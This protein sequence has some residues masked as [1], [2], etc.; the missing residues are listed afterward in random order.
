MLSSG[1]EQSA[2]METSNASSEEKPNKDKTVVDHEEVPPAEPNSTEM[3]ANQTEAVP[4]TYIDHVINDLYETDAK[5]G[6]QTVP[7]AADMPACSEMCSSNLESNES[8]TSLPPQPNPLDFSLLDSGNKGCLLPTGKTFLNS[9]SRNYNQLSD[10]NTDLSVKGCEE[11]PSMY[12]MLDDTE[13]ESDSA[14][15]SAVKTENPQGDCKDTQDTDSDEEVELCYSVVRQRQPNQEKGGS[16]SLQQDISGNQT[17]KEMF[18]DEVPQKAPSRLR[19]VKTTDVSASIT[20][21]Q[22]P[23]PHQSASLES[24]EKKQTMSV[25]QGDLSNPEPSDCKSNEKMEKAVAPVTTSVTHSTVSS[26]NNRHV[27]PRSRDRTSKMHSNELFTSDKPNTVQVPLMSAVTEPPASH[28]SSGK[29]SSTQATKDAETETTHDAKSLFSETPT[30]SSTRSPSEYKT[31]NN[32]PVS[33]SSNSRIR[34]EEKSSCSAKL[35][36]LSIRSKNKG[37]EQTCSKTAKAESPLL[38][39]ANSTPNQSPKLPAKRSAPTSSPQMSRSQDKGISVLIKTGTQSQESNATDLSEGLKANVES[40]CRS[41]TEPESSLPKQTDAGSKCE[42][43]TTQRTFIEVR[44]SSSSS[45]SSPTSAPVLPCTETA[46]TKSIQVQESHLIL[47]ENE[48]SAPKPSLETSTASDSSMSTP[49]R[50]H[51]IKSPNKPND[52]VCSIIS[53]STKLLSS[54]SK[55]YLKALDR[56]SY[57]TDSE[58]LKRHS[59]S[60]QQRIKSFENLASLDR[61]VIK[62]IDIQSYAVGSKAAINKRLSGPLQSNDHRSLKRSLSSCVEMLNFGH[63]FS[64]QS[65]NSSSNAVINNSESSPSSGD[66]RP[67][68][69]ERATPEDAV[70]RSSPVPH[71]PPVLRT[72]NARYNGGILRSK[73]RELRALSMPE[74]DKLYTQD[75]SQDPGHV[76]FKTELEIQPTRPSKSPSDNLQCTMVTRMSMVEPGSVNNGEQTVKQ[77][78]WSV[79]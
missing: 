72:R 36:G 67:V 11:K 63:S 56:R 26:Q 18:A 77:S 59:F 6:S 8:V 48:E 79:R 39:K 40:E 31:L 55:L 33:H 21:P 47:K 14:T 43:A 5:S 73:L 1:T 44:L 53:E 7:D 46:N 45:P 60:V 41:E 4:V 25:T 16:S 68:E 38:K 19:D 3:D 65:Q 54:K 57:S 2:K 74:L 64:L 24:S 9:Y 70:P 23:L 12:N 52:K 29:T 34:F 37:L 69:E 76:T 30:K 49:E 22:S 42:S 66:Y 10:E 78:S 13:S 17:D 61:P 58:A 62:G 32:N 27:S 51:S 75:F 20:A 15:D 35:K 71:T 28:F 50:N